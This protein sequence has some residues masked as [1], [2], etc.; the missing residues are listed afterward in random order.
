MRIILLCIML[1]SCGKEAK[2]IYT[3]VTPEKIITLLDMSHITVDR[4]KN[5]MS[6]DQSFE[7]S[8]SASL[9]MA[10]V[11]VLDQGQSGTCV[12]FAATAAID[13]SLAIGDFISQQCSLQLNKSLGTDGWDGLYYPSQVIDP[14]KK[15]GVVSQIGCNARYPSRN[16]PISVSDYQ[17]RSD[18]SVSASVSNIRYTYYSQNNL[19]ALKSAV[20]AG[21]RVLIGFLLNPNKAA[22][23]DLPGKRSGLWSCSAG[24][25][26]P[27]PSP[28]ED[29][30]QQCKD[31]FPGM[32]WLCDIFF[33]KEQQQVS[34]A[35]ECGK[36]NA[37]HEIIVYGYDD[38]KQRLYIRN[39]WGVNIGNSGDFEMTY[40]Y[41]S[42]QV[43]D[44]TV[45]E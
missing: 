34:A 5:I 15:Y 24:G 23:F 1:F 36:W 6:F 26:E 33:S 9:G 44:M 22:G 27:V 11:P 7:Y 42:R 30:L 31:A 37:G 43:I 39:S 3:F 18:K 35:S 19:S 12:T 38:S 4:Y 41:F 45:I 8:G 2:A 29:A 20:S 17:S 32:E 10:N 28:E 14:L 13:A 25:S 40:E 16:V 21:K